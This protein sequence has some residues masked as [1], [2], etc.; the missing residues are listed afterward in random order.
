MT[1]FETSD[2]WDAELDQ[3]VGLVHEH[4]GAEAMDDA[5]ERALTN[6]TTSLAPDLEKPDMATG[7][8][9]V[10]YDALRAELRRLVRPH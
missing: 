5:I 9:S 8:M 4:F 6:A 7:S 1:K 10:F 3:L 2:G